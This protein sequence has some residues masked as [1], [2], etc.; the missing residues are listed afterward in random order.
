[1]ILAQVLKPEDGF[2]SHAFQI[3]LHFKVGTEQCGNFSQKGIWG[4]VLIL[5]H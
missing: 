2:M 1:M 4:N 3:T 5:C